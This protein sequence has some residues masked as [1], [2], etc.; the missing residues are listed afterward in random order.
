[1]E[2]TAFWEMAPNSKLRVGKMLPKQ[3][4][5]IC[6]LGFTLLLGAGSGFSASQNDMVEFLVGQR[7]RSVN[8]ETKPDDQTRRL[9]A[10]GRFQAPSQDFSKKV[11]RQQ[12]LTAA[13][14]GKR[15]SPRYPYTIQ[16][17][18]EKSSDRAAFVCRELRRQKVA[19]FYYQ[20]K[21]AGGGNW[22]RVNIGSYQTYSEA[23]YAALSLRQGRFK[24][25]FVV[26]APY[27]VALVDPPTG[28]AQKS[29]LADLNLAAYQRPEPSSADTLVGAFKNRQAAKALAQRLSQK[30]MKAVV[31]RR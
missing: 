18:S 8:A 23:H 5:I 6:F 12:P 31:I 13:L 27:A 30:G 17:L 29:R 1:M 24:D 22:Y 20:A 21:V 19:A 28:K 26:K 25:A 11:P 15:L 3:T 10:P 16:I 9:A 4:F 2:M 14:D 7:V